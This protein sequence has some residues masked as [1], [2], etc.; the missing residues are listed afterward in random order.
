ML[1]FLISKLKRGCKN[2]K[3]STFNVGYKNIHDFSHFAKLFIR[4][5]TIRWIKEKQMS[6]V[7]LTNTL[8]TTKIFNQDVY[9]RRPGEQQTH[10]VN[11][12]NLFQGTL[13]KI[14]KKIQQKQSNIEIE[15]T[16]Y[17]KIFSQNKMTNF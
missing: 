2:F 17:F 5:Y 4:T 8:S 3:H 16:N 6:I 1:N 15:D 10:Q 14:S 13:N 9:K 12:Q 7:E 11:A